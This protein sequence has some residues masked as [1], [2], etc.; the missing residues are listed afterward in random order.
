MCI[1]TKW[2]NIKSSQVVYSFK[3]WLCLPLDWG[4]LSISV[5]K[6][7]RQKYVENKKTLFPKSDHAWFLIQ[8]TVISDNGC[9]AISKLNENASLWIMGGKVSPIFFTTKKLNCRTSIC[10]C[11]C[12]NCFWPSD[13][14]LVWSRA[15]SFFKHLLTELNYVGNLE[16][17]WWRW[18]QV[19]QTENKA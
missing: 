16:C 15:A 10:L 7:E 1:I 2:Y 6:G 8:L 4:R 13:I 9:Y 17:L 19:V 18:G 5:E 12:H 11:T 14:A 3:L